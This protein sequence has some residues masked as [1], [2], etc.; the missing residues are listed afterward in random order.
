[1]GLP[2]DERKYRARVVESV[3]VSH[4]W[5]MYVPIT[6]QYTSLHRLP[7]LSCLPCF[8]CHPHILQFEESTTV[9][10]ICLGHGGACA[11]RVHCQLVA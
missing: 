5:C 6:H 7:S 9:G 3:C 10:L 8:L 1:M 11:I 2:V 4:T